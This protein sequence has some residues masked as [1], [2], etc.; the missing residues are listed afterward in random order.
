MGLSNPLSPLTTSMTRPFTILTPLVA[1]LLEDPT[2]M[3]VLLDVRSLS[4]PT[5]DGVPTEE[6]PSL[7]KTPQRPIVLPPTPLVG[8]PR[9]LLPQDFAEGHLYNF[10]TLLEFH[11]LFPSLLTLTELLPT[12]SPMLTLLKLLTRTSIFVLDVSSGILTLS[13][14]LCARLLPTVTSDVRTLT[15]HGRR[16]RS[17]PFKCMLLKKYTFPY[18]KVL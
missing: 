16:S 7:E 2:E 3:P 14:L 6:E 15:S 18:S 8:L 13:A 12:E 5:E 1:S 17:F 11:T 4:T 10:P 9:V